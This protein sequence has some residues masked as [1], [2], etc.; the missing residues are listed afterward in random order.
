LGDFLEFNGDVGSVAIQDGGVSVLDGSGVVKN[1][2]LGEEGFSGSGGVSLGIRGNVSSFDFLDGDVFDVETNV[3][4]WNSFSELFVM[5]FNGFNSGGFIRGGEVDIHVGFE[6]TSFDSSDG[7]CSNTSNFVNILERK[8][9]GFFG[10]S[11]GGNNQIKSLEKSG[12]RV[13]RSVG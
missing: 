2:D 5:H 12:S 9:E 1:D 11:F 10:G 3:V 4:S 6:D 8:S 7:D 13:P